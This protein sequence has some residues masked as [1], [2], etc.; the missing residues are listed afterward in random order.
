MGGSSTGQ[1]VTQEVARCG[2]LC[3]TATVLK[4]ESQDPSLRLILKKLV[5]PTKKTGRSQ[6]GLLLFESGRYLVM[7]AAKERKTEAVLQAQGRTTSE[8]PEDNNIT[9]HVAWET[10]LEE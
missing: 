1:P 3:P 7:K 4:L 8:L 10:P 5:L 2:R 6:R 9:H